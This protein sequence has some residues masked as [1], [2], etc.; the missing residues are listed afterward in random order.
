MSV[1]G[2]ADGVS[3]RLPAPRESELF[4]RY[5]RDRAD[6]PGSGWAPMAWEGPDGWEVLFVL[7]A[8]KTPAGEGEVFIDLNCITDRSRRC[9]GIMRGVPDPDGGDSP[10]RIAAFT[11]PARWRGTYR[12]IAAPGASA[13]LAEWAHARRTGTVGDVPGHRVYR[14]APFSPVAEFAVPDAPLPRWADVGGGA[15]A[16]GSAPVP[17]RPR[18]WAGTDR[19]VREYRYAGGSGVLVVLDGAQFDSFGLAGRIGRVPTPPEVVLSIGSTE[20]TWRAVE[21][22]CDAALRD[23]V[24]E[25]ARSLV[26]DGPLQVLGS[27]LG[28]AAATWWGLTRPD[29][30]D[31]AVALSGSYWLR[32]AEGEP[33]WRAAAAGVSCRLHLGWGDCESKIAPGCREAVAELGRRGHRLTTGTWVGGHDFVHWADEAVS[34]LAGTSPGTHCEQGKPYL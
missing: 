18:L 22:A 17:R 16:A 24:L 12:F 20:A 15:G 13:P 6:G 31:R 26:D 5:L 4:D 34:V 25:V 30:V 2:A 11:L 9:E 21:Y 23:S 28:G 10:L 1:G 7:P 8:G 3:Y 19:Y 29:L 14:G 32:D 27:S 33:V